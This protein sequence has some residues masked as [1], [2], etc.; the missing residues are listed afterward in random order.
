MTVMGGLGTSVIGW[1]QDTE[2]LPEYSRDGADSCFACHDEDQAVLALFR[3]RH[4]IPSDAHG[5]FGRG[6]LQCEAC[7]GPGAEH[8][9]RVRRGKERPTTYAFGAEG[10]APVERDNAHCLSCHA[11]DAGAPWHGGAHEAN[12]VGCADCHQSH[13]PRDP[14][15]YPATQ[16]QVCTTCHTAQK[17]QISKH[18]NHPV[19]VGKMA[20]SDCHNPHGA[21]EVNDLT[22]PTANETCYEC[23][24]EKRGPFLWEHAPVAEDCNSCHLPHGSNHPGM[25][26]RRAP[27]LCQ[28]CH[29]QAGH[30]S[31]AQT[32]EGL[33]EGMP[34][35]FLLGESCMN[36]HSQVHGSNHPSGS[37][38]MR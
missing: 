34:S 31:I 37:K 35:Q 21:T 4:A 10:S 36:C 32:V 7:H 16:A 5:P 1:A 29:S 17:I 2:A 18:F 30:P 6:Q 13:L 38:L 9:K 19:A 23:H 8:S 24:A 11:A 33:P 12:D 15:L 27:L 25:L 22:R 28:S 3:G 26:T 20:C 14:V